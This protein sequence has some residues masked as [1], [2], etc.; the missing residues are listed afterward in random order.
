MK[1]LH[2]LF[3]LS[4]FPLF[5]GAQNPDIKRTYHW[6]FGEKAGL[7]FSSGS[8]VPIVNSAM[9]A[10]EGC[11]S[12]SDTC[13][14][15][16]FYTDGDTVWNKNNQPMPNGTGLMGCGSSTQSSLIV[17]QPGNDSIYYIFT[18][19]CIENNGTSGLRYSVVNINM[20]GG[21]GSVIQTNILLYAPSSEK[22]AATY[23]ANGTDIWIL[24][25]NRYPP[26]PPPDTTMQYYAYLLTA[27]GININ[28]IISPSSIKPHKG[29]YTYLTFSH[30]GNKIINNWQV[31]SLGADSLEIFDFNKNTGA[32][33]NLIR[34]HQDS[35]EGVY[36][37]V[38]SSDD[39]KLYASVYNVFSA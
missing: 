5:A 20:S 34:I 2:A 33:S 14:E 27:S 36:G 19:D 4:L 23:H 31:G 10:E 28:P 32:L 22:L 7:D 17:P 24:S 15:L 8:P 18:T 25:V 6:Y 12:I 13:G 38:F 11:A 9:T 26:G 37:L 29:Y 1:N 16:L 3:L 21:Y 30:Q 39:S 35:L